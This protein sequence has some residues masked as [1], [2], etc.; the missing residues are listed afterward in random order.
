M[1]VRGQDIYG[2]RVRQRSFRLREVR[3]HDPCAFFKEDS[4]TKVLRGR[5]CK[6]LVLF[7]ED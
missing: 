4:D 6:V 7:K 2:F 1:R 3:N 5:A